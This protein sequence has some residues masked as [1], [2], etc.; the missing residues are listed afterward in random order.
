MWLWV[1][2]GKKVGIEWDGLDSVTGN[3]VLDGKLAQG[4]EGIRMVRCVCFAMCALDEGENVIDGLDWR[5]R[6]GMERSI[7]IPSMDAEWRHHQTKH[8][9][10]DRRTI[11][12][13]QTDHSHSP[14][15]SQSTTQVY[16]PKPH[17]QP[18]Q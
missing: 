16:V 1:A 10:R 4:D 13:Y 14:T 9:D 5:L 8:Q 3:K 12:A 17:Q 6:I 15:S 2:R 7:S 11:T 18:N